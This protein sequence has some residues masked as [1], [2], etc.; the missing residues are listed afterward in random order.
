MSVRVLAPCLAV[1]LVVPLWGRPQPA[2]PD[3]TIQDGVFTEAQADRGQNR[4]ESYCRKCHGEDLTGANARALVGEDFLRN[5]TGLTLDGLLERAQT[6]PPGAAMSLGTE[7]YVDIITYVLETNGFPPGS[8]EL[9]ADTLSTVVVEGEDGPQEA[10]DH[11]LVQVVGCL[12]RGPSNTWMVTNATHPVRTRDPSAS[13]EAERQ[14][15]EAMTLGSASY[16]LLYVFPAPDSLVGHRV[17][18]K[19]FL[20]RGEPDRINVTAVTAVTALDGAAPDC[21][22]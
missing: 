9:S 15:A 4:Y 1:A 11:T 7:T 22:R 19:G 18:A 10:P 2:V 5:W 20:I 16:E 6:M 17:E 12:A 14:V 13:T 8:D 21:V 3:R